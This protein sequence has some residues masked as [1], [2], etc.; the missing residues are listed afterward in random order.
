MPH[1]TAGGD[2][3][4]ATPRHRGWMGIWDLA[5]PVIAQVHG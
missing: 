4:V 5:K 1:Y 3:P 2:G